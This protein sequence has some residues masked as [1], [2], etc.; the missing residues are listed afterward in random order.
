[1]ALLLLD[2]S[3]PVHSRNTPDSGGN[4]PAVTVQVCRAGVTPCQREVNLPVGGEVALDLL[5]TVA[6]GGFPPPAPAPVAWEAHFLLTGSA[7]MELVAAG[8]A[9]GPVKEQGSPGLAL[10]GL[11]RLY[12]GAGPAP[13]PA[14]R[15]YRVQNSYDPATGRLDFSV[16]LAGFSAANPSAGLMD[17]TPGTRL[18][19][20]TITV[21]GTA[22]G[23][24]E[25]AAADSAGPS[26]QIVSATPSGA[27]MPW[28]A[29]AGTPLAVVNVG[30][31]AE[32]A[33]LQGL[34]WAQMPYGVEKPHPFQGQFTLT[35]WT[36]GAVPPWRGGPAKPVAAFANLTADGL[37]GFTVKDL[38]RELIPPGVYDL[39][40]KGVG[41]LSGLVPAVSVDTSGAAPG[42]LPAPVVADFGVLPNGDLN[43]DNLVDG[44]D[45]AALK[46]GFGKDAADAAFNPAAD[47][48]RD[49]VVDGQDFSLLAAN[50]DRIGE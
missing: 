41:A 15:Y 39:R 3:P 9:G 10:D 24:S 45:L 23:R 6:A 13:A 28:L 16:T 18:R 49:Q 46:S 50:L 17:L 1:M 11:A 26:F 37:G 42:N 7:G 43:G 5:L 25:L 2:H 14:G 47:F 21:R 38:P 8:P 40:V 27:A 44:A 36:E 32:K 31:A 48:N 22:P 12:P 4:G 20:G 19:M 34:V 35:F 29:G 33:R 30:P